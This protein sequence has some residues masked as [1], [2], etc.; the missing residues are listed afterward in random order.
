VSD[1][2]MPVAISFAAPDRIL[3]AYARW[4][5]RPVSRWLYGKLG[6]RRDRPPP[7]VLRV[8]VGAMAMSALENSGPQRRGRD[9][10]WGRAVG[11]PRPQEGKTRSAADGTIRK[12]RG[13]TSF[14][15]EARASC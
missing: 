12:P 2:D 3:L 10:R 15:D 6:R 13:L 11:E 14:L 5:R 1:P 4:G 9:P 7:P 8:S